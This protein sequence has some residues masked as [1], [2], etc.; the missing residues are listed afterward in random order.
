LH[1]THQ[2]YQ[3]IVSKDIRHILNADSDRVKLKYKRIIVHYLNYAQYLEGLKKTHW[4]CGTLFKYSRKLRGLVHGSFIYFNISS[5]TDTRVIRIYTNRYFYVPSDRVRCTYHRSSLVGGK[6]D[7]FSLPSDAP[8]TAC[9]RAFLLM[10]RL[11]YRRKP[12]FIAS[13]VM[14]LR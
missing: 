10:V 3:S 4:N 13:A 2:S 5:W 6:R 9:L 1:S 7:P 8:S 11:C 12:R 14:Q